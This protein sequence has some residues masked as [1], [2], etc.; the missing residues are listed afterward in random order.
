MM[1]KR[2]SFTITANAFDVD[3]NGTI[4]RVEFF[5]GST[6]IGEATEA[7]YSFA[8]NDVAPG[9]YI[10]TAKAT[11]TA[12][13]ATTSAPVHVIVSASLPIFSDNFNDNWLDPAKWSVI[14]SNSSAVVSETGQ[15]LQITLAPNTAG[16]NGVVSNSTFDLTG[17]MVQVEVAQP[18]SQAGWCE[19][20]IQVVSDAKNYYLIDVGG[21]SLVFRSMVNGVNDQLVI[22][23]DPAAFPYWRIR[24]NEKANTVSFET[25]SDGINW[26]TRKVVAAGFSLEKVSFYLY[27]GAWGTGNSNPGAAKYD[28]F[29]LRDS[30]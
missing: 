12:N 27:A 19:N 28:N 6:K 10:L 30:P 23:Y 17:R 20:F 3:G 26:T 25:S 13:A 22:A 29:Q 7:P 1:I 21:G 18:V 5:Q 11:D 4:A 24:H 8:W 15:R 9:S 14:D 2:T 16:Y